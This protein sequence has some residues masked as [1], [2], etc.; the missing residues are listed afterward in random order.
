MDTALKLLK[1]DLGITHTLRDDYFNALLISCK[2]EIENKGAVLDLSTVEDSKLLSDYACWTYRKRQEDV[3][4]GRSL[5][6]RIRNKIMQARSNY[7][8]D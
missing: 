7:V 1:I 6:L 5:Q 3:E 2:T 8:A 4:L